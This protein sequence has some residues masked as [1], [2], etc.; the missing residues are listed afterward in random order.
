MIADA[1]TIKRIRAQAQSHAT[2]KIRD[3]V[4]SMDLPLDDQQI[5]VLQDAI[6]IAYLRGADAGYAAC[7]AERRERDAMDTAAKAEERKP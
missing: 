4:L 3:L 1:D 6:G 5:S 2:E 7:A